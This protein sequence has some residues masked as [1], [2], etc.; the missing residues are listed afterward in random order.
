MRPNCTHRQS[1]TAGWTITLASL[2][3][4]LYLVRPLGAQESPSPPSDWTQ[5]RG[6]QRDGTLRNANPWPATLS[7]NQLVEKWTVPL[8][9]SY[10]GPLVV[11]DHVFVTETV[12]EQE[13][14]VRCLNRETGQE[15]W[16]VNWLGAMKVPFFAAKNGSWIRSTPAYANGKLF[17]AGIRDVLVSLDA[18]TGKQIWKRDFP[19]EMNSPIPQFGCVCSPLTDGE[20]VYMQAGGAMHKIHQ[21]T[22]ETVWQACPDGPGKNSS[23]FSSPAIETVAGKRQLIVQG[24]TELAEHLS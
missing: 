23:I 6:D 1:L 11:G 20:Y 24:R 3:V 21:Q 13:E 10:S 16:K 5:W 12:N 7:V 22:G 8:G 9:P 18:Q 14:F 2:L 17:V 19:I 4:G 15:I